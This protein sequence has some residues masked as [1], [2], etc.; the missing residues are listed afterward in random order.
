MRYYICIIGIIYAIVLISCKKEDSELP[1]TGYGCIILGDEEGFALECATKVSSQSYVTVEW[2]L[3]T[4][5]GYRH[6][7]EFMSKNKKTSVLVD[8]ITKNKNILLS[9]EYRCWGWG[10]TYQRSS[11]IHFSSNIIDLGLFEPP[12]KIFID[13]EQYDEDKYSI[14]IYSEEKDYY[15]TFTGGFLE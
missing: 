1:G 11:Y 10:A 14:K 2:N 6:T 3:A 15:I 7:L 5:V 12:H 13:V 9:D 4:F 8:I